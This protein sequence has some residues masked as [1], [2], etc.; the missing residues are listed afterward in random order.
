MASAQALAQALEGLAFDAIYSSPLQRARRTAEVIHQG[1]SQPPVLQIHDK[2]LEIDLPLWEGLNK[3][4]VK[5]QFPE[6]YLTW[7]EQPAQFCMELDGGAGG[8]QQHYPVPAVFEQARQFWQEILPKHQGKTVLVVGHNGI[9]RS[10]ICTAT[11]MGPEQYQVIRQSNCGVSVLNFAGHLGDPVQL[12]SINLT[13]HLGETI[14]DHRLKGGCRLLLVRHGETEWN[15][16]SRFQGQIDIPLNDTGKAQAQKAAEFLK[17]VALDFAITSPLSRPKETAQII[18]QHHPGVALAE[19]ADLKEIGHGLWE[20]KLEQEIRAEY[21][22]ALQQ[23]KVAPHTVQMPEGETLQQVWDRGVAAWEAIVRQAPPNTTGL[24]V[25]HDAVNKAIL[26]HV[27]GLEPKDIWAVKQG[28]GAVTVVDYPRGLAG[29][30]T[31]QALNITTHFGTG[32]I[33]RTAAGAL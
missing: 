7:K 11:G 8:R 25:A 2:L 21:G 27:L 4:E 19:V 3:S 23:W 14:P 26:C 28:N 12:E 9:L 29:K 13:G 5:A 1:L 31:L 6:S 32:I 18:L 22:E 33:D 30:P 24:V 16:L 15:R 20:G 17:D 10:L